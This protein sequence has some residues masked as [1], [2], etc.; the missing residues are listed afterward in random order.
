MKYSRFLN[1]YMLSYNEKL[2][3]KLGGAMAEFISWKN[4]DEVGNCDF[5]HK[6]IEIKKTPQ[7]L[8]C[9]ALPHI[10]VTNKITGFVEPLL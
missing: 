6:I 7:F 8:V 2:W 4:C 3:C 5:L 1:D 10:L 9:Y